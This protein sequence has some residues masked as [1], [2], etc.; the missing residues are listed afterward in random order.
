[1]EYNSTDKHSYKNLGLTAEGAGKAR[2]LCFPKQK[3][4]LDKEKCRVLI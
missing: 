3:Q 4:I 2:F 1:M